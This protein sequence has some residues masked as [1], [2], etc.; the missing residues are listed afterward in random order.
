MQSSE[1]RVINIIVSSP[2][3]VEFVAHSGLSM[4]H[5]L[6]EIEIEE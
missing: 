4:Y 6:R 1:L 5:K 3:V 2:V